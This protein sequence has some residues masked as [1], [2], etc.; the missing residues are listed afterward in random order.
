M[1][2]EIVTITMFTICL[3]NRT[4]KQITQHYYRLTDTKRASNRT[5]IAIAL[6]LL[7]MIYLVSRVH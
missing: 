7:Y 2:A 4:V 1:Q 6:Y 3:S 5:V